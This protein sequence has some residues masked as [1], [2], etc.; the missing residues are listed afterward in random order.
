MKSYD[1]NKVTFEFKRSE[2]AQQFE[3][4]HKVACGVA[5]K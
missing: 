3:N 1:A 5:A 2:Y 4:L